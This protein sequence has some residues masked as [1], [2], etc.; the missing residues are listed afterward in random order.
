RRLILLFRNA[1]RLRDR[2]VPF[3]SHDALRRVFP[4]HR[5]E[6]EAF[7]V[8]AGDDPRVGHL[9]MYVDDEVAARRRLVMASVGLG[10]RSVLQQR[11]TMGDK[12]ARPVDASLV[13]PAIAGV[14]IRLLWIDRLLILPSLSAATAAPSATA[15]T[16]SATTGRIRG[17]A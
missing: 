13:G 16:S 12:A 8:S 11:E 5:T 10:D 1:E 14:G 7:G 17:G 9:R 6:L 4:D 3:D 15:A 2:R